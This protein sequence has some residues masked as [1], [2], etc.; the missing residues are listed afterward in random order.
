MKKYLF[1]NCRGYFIIANLEII[2]DFKNSKEYISSYALEEVDNKKIRIKTA[3]PKEQ[4]LGNFLLDFMNTDFDDHIDFTIFV[5]DY[6]F[7]HLLSLY[8]NKILGDINN[9]SIVLNK[10]YLQ[11]FIDWIYDELSLDFSMLKK[12]IF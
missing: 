5:K 4:E 7:I 10:E 9:Y 12:K 8:D 1:L 11:D 3:G 2:F 6:L